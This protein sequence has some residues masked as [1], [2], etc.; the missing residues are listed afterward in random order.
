MKK[1]ILTLMLLAGLSAIQAQP[2]ADNTSFLSFGAGGVMYRHSGEGGFSLPAAGAAYGRWIMRPLA[3]R[4]GADMTMAPSHFQKGTSSS[5]IFLMGSAE[6]MWDVNAIFFHVYNKNYQFPIPFYPFVG[7]GAVYRPA[8]TVN[9]TA[10]EM[11]VDFQIVLGLNAPFR[12]SSYWDL[13][14]EYKCFFY[15]QNFDGSFGDNFMNTFTLGVTRRWS[16]NPYHRRSLFESRSSG[17][18]WF[19]GLGIGPNFSSFAFE[20][21]DKLGMYGITPEIFV[22]RNYSEFWTVRL[23]LAGLTAHERYDEVKDTAGDRYVFTTIHTDL[24]MNLSHL[25][26]FSRGSRFNF[27]PYLGAGL[28]WRYDQLLFDMQGDAGMM[29]RYYIGP[30]GDV[31]AD[32][33]YTMVHSRIGGGNKGGSSVRFLTGIPS[34][35]VGYIHNIGNNST[36]YRIPLDWAPQ[37]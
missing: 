33:R 20:H 19:F 13:F 6:F 8:V 9:D 10:Y 23:G 37:M 21:I 16:D 35:T 12:I 25:F 1:L 11:D 24:M 28:V 26:S 3:F 17:E 2:V 31:Y 32:L 34:I 18:D 36:R 7:L 15:P 30:R 4:I 14:F 29:F 22:G 27:M 5:T